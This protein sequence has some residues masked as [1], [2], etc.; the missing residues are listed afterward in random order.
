MVEGRVKLL[1][2]PRHGVRLK[3]GNSNGFFGVQS[4][5]KVSIGSIESKGSLGLLGP[6]GLLGP[7]EF[8]WDFWVLEHTKT[9]TNTHTHTHTHTT[10]PFIVDNILEGWCP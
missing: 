3:H 4:S 8:F 2:V 1:Y 6:Q 9:H 5:L 7:P 10:H